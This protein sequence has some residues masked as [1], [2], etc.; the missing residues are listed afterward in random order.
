MT[1]FKDL[2]SE[3]QLKHCTLKFN[4]AFIPIDHTYEVKTECSFDFKTREEYLEFVKDW[5]NRYKCVG[6]SL[7]VLK[8]PVGF[9][10]SCSLG[11]VYLY[12]R[13]HNPGGSLVL[14]QRSLQIMAK[15]LLCARKAGKNQA[16]VQRKIQC[17]T[18]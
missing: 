2:K 11:S 14:A 5:K 4:L 1:T 18:T 3:I 6:E 8:R 12:G 7:R 13:Y 10:T 15:A 16:A 9:V 17:R